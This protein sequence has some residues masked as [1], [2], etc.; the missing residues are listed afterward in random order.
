MIKKVK[1]KPT[2]D[3][4]TPVHV[5]LDMFEYRGDISDSSV[6]QEFIPVDDSLDGVILCRLT[7]GSYIISEIHGRHADY[8]MVRYPMLMENFANGSV[9]F[10][11]F[12]PSAS[13]P[14]TIYRLA[15]SATVQPSS[16][17]VLKYQRYVHQKY[18]K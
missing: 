5:I 17:L 1:D 18:R 4:S 3:S 11:E 14:V 12:I 15:I 13:G 7:D 10:S 9:M 8:L 2:F 16:D 6:K